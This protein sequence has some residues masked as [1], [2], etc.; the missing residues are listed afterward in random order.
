M[1]FSIENS[2]VILFILFFSKVNQGRDHTV[3]LAVTE[4]KSRFCSNNKALGLI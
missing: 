1:S 2:V 4:C 3:V